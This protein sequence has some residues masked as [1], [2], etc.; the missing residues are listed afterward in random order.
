MIFV[1]P[2]HDIGAAKGLSEA[3][4]QRVQ[5]AEFHHHGDRSIPSQQRFGGFA[6]SLLAGLGVPVE[7]QFGLRPAAAQDGS[8]APIKIETSTDRL[9]LL[10]GVVTFNL[11]PHLPHL[12][13]PGEAVS[14]LEVLA[15]Q[16]IDLSA[17][18]HEF[19]QRGHKGGVVFITS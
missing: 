9:S 8:P 17:P 4:R 14:G 10:K 12:H 7:N 18:P 5:E 1:C 3:D 13:C 16:P 15:R 6:R 11:H 19:V 2:H